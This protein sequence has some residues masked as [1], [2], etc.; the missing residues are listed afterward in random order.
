MSEESCVHNDAI[1]DLYSSESYQNFTS[2]TVQYF[3]THHSAGPI[4]ES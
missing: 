2:D 1:Y 3:D 4:S